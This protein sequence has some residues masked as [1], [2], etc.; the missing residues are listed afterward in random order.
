[1]R[2]LLLIIVLLTTGLLNAHSQQQ[3]INGTV[4]DSQT[5]QSLPFATIAVENAGKQVNKFAADQN[6]NFA[7]DAT[8]GYVIKVT[9]TGYEP[10][11]VTVGDTTNI[12]ILLK[13]NS[14]LSEVV[15]IAYGKEKRKDLT[16]AV[17]SISAQQ[18]SEV[19]STNLATAL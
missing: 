17:S 11:K 19:P 4:K 5:G 3:K 1:M 15:V 18:I 10:K 12:T 2:K 13:S 9:F 7:V 14:N 16:S 6:G 8:V